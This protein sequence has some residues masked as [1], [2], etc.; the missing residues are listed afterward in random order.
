MGYRS[1]QWTWDISCFCNEHIDVVL[2]QVWWS[3]SVK[4]W[5]WHLLKC[6]CI[7]TRGLSI[8]HNDF[9]LTFL[10]KL[11]S[12]CWMITVTPNEVALLSFIKSLTPCKTSSFYIIFSICVGE[13]IFLKWYRTGCVNCNYTFYA[14]IPLFPIFSKYVPGIRALSIS[15][16][17]I[18]SCFQSLSRL[19]TF[20]LPG[21]AKQAQW[22]RVNISLSRCKIYQGTD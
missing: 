8:G 13:D 5:T 19:W 22:C 16:D 11:L 1:C 15:S 4:H 10:K 6:K 20:L 7:I 9:S 2:N 18:L 21:Y 12:Q 17:L 3:S 14:A